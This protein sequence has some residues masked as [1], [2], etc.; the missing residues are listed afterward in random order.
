MLY[1]NLKVTLKDKFLLVILMIV[2]TVLIIF[3]FYVKIVIPLRVVYNLYMHALY[4]IET[5]K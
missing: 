1:F 2:I 3:L 4:S 5:T